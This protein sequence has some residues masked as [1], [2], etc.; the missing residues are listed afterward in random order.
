MGVNK[1]RDGFSM[2]S[3]NG[4]TFSKSTTG[5]DNKLIMGVRD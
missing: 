1:N 3:N 4:N 5:D 2:N